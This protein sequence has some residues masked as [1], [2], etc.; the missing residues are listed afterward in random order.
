M[1][2]V[3]YHTIMVKAILSVFNFTKLVINI[4]FI[5][6]AGQLLIPQAQLAAP[7]IGNMATAGSHARHELFVTLLG[8]MNW[9]PTLISYS[10]VQKQ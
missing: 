7:S 6:L 5:A 8:L 9:L 3:I 1:V 2:M 10:H 4:R